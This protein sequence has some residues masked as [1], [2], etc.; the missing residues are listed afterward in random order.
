MKTSSE[1]GQPTSLAALKVTLIPPLV[2]ARAKEPSGPKVREQL[3]KY[4]AAEERGCQPTSEAPGL[5]A[6]FLLQK[7]SFC[8]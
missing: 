8:I 3:M 1:Y 2:A 6:R 4:A 7:S 5:L